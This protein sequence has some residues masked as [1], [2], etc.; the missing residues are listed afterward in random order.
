MK[1]NI[2]RTLSKIAVASSVVALAL[3]LNVI[4]AWTEP[5]AVPPANNASAPI[6]VSTADQIKDGGLGVGALAV[7]GDALIQGITETQGGLIIEKRTTDPASPV[8]G[9]MWL[10]TDL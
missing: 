8:S 9:R 3:G 1:E 7:F 2:R 10:R 5:T 6:N 4:H